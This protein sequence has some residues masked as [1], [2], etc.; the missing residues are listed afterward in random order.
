[1]QSMK[2]IAIKTKSHHTRIHWAY[3]LSFRIKPVVCDHKDNSLCISYVQIQT[4]GALVNLFWKKKRKKSE[5][6]ADFQWALKSCITM[7]L[8][9][10]HKKHHRQ[11]KWAL[12]G[13]TRNHLDSWWKVQFHNFSFGLSL[14][15]GHSA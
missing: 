9:I 3:K 15:K 7:A 11:N 10:R 12:P 5:V 4:W 13:I 2:L 1:M 6:A 14:G 8:V